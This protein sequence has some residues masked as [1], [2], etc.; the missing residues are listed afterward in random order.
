MIGNDWLPWSYLSDGTK[1]LFYIITE[2]ISIENGIILVEE[3]ELGIHPHQLF[4][5]MD[6]LKEQSRTKQVIITT[7]SPMVL[8]I[9]NENELDR[10]T[11]AE[12]DKET[13]FLKLNE[14]QISKAKE[15]INEVGELS[16]YWLH[17]DLEK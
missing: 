12:Y 3:P 16:Y 17:S 11:I 7:H 14:E 1:R 13:K 6:F 9:L 8:D 15:Y 2:C 10:I 5:L 4:K